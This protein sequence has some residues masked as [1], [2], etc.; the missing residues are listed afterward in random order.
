MQPVVNIVRASAGSGKTHR[1]THEYIDLLL[2]G[3]EQSYKH[4]LAV[5]FTNK[6]TDEMKQRVIESLYDLSRSGDIR[7]EEAR[8]R[9]SLILHDY[10]CFSISTIDR[11]FQ[12]VM[13]AF[14]REIGQYASYRVELDTKAVLQQAVDRLVD[15]LDDPQNE[16]LLSWLQDYSFELI[17]SGRGWNVREPLRNMASL[18]FKEDFRMKMRSMPG[19]IMGD[20]QAVRKLGERLDALKSQFENSLK[21][22][23]KSALAAMA[24]GGRGPDEFKGKS[25]GPFM[26]FSKWASWKPGDKLPEPSEKLEESW[27]GFESPGLAACVEEA[28]RLFG[29][30]WK[31]YRS[32]VV[33]RANLPLLGI[34]SDIFHF[35]SEYLQE[36]NVVLLS[37]SS[38]LLSRIID[39]DD[40]PFVYEKIGNR[41]DHLM[42]DESQDTSVLQWGNFKPLFSNS[43]AQGHKNLIVG[44]VKQSIYRWRGSDWHLLDSLMVRDLGPGNVGETTLLENWRSGRSIVDF[45]NR[46]FSGVADAIAADAPAGVAEQVKSIYA[47]CVQAV[48]DLRSSAPEGQVQLSFLEPED[49]GAAVLGRMLSDIRALQGQGFMH[50]DMTI[51]VRK[52]VQGAEVANY[53]IANGIDVVTE[54][55][56]LI[57]SSPLIRRT[58]A[59]L[60][61]LVEPDDPVGQL[62][63][64]GLELP[65][66]QAL[67]GSVYEVCERLLASPGLVPEETDVPFIHAFLD[68]VLAWQEKYGSSLRGFLKW[69]D[70]VGVKE[71]ICAPDGQDAV[72]VMTIHK[73]KG[74]SLEAVFIPFTD[75]PF[76]TSAVLAPTLWCEAPEEWGAAGL[77]PVKA[78]RNMEGTFFEK[79]LA[80]E[81]VNQYVDVLNMS[82]VAFTRAKSRLYIYAPLPGKPGDY[83]VKDM[84]SLLYKLFSGSLDADGR[85]S[86][87]SAEAFVRRAV[88]DTLK[89]DPQLSFGTVPLGEHRLRLALRSGDYFDIEPSARKHG[90][91]RHREMARVEVDA[92]LERQSGGRHWFD[93]SYRVF[94]EATIVTG[95]G[96]NYRPDRVL[97]APDGSRVV[98]IDYKFGAPRPEH[99]RQ[100][101]GY[102]DLMDRMGYTAVEGWLWYVEAGETVRV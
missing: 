43:I 63:A 42:L 84:S 90:I 95:D 26:V 7:A 72:R 93:G 86:C 79:D 17:E 30:P 50:R 56:L 82:Y 29:E 53:L 101:R 55:S 91:D 34:Y 15:A 85:W 94:N 23:G 89:D 28:F 64:E 2:A 60:H 19:S 10:S 98:V 68:H 13:R 65:D 18:F 27:N 52:N 1:L 39:D 73:S 20:K 41:Y 76:L 38:D 58:V 9:L 35:L 36:N 51:L 14:A 67:R 5:T 77:L 16:E 78:Q 3:D 37:Q 24:A 45:N 59:L 31:A 33:V 81:R 74:L 40:T 96:E 11:F 71:N 48:P 6:A 47:D 87:G 92:E 21:E 22:L 88:S 80:N 49:Y 102:M 8:R 12:G 46:V 54:D 32:A 70:E 69:W 4:I 44:D 100:V 61:A 66:A 57:S 83:A 75:E 62:L 25:R 99:A 97:I